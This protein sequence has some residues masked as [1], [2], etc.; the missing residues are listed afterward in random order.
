MI[1]FRLC[2]H[3][4]ACN[5]CGKQQTENTPIHE[6]R[7]STTGQDWSTLM[8]CEE[9]LEQL[10]QKLKEHEQNKTLRNYRDVLE[11][12]NLASI[13][14]ENWDACLGKT[15]REIQDYALELN[16][17]SIDDEI[18]NLNSILKKG[19]TTRQKL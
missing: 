14:D 7:M 2:K 12:Y 11:D 18:N 19:K 1:D 5:N 6:L 3:H 4:G 9:C 13:I 15:M 16:T 8:L 10:R 17:I